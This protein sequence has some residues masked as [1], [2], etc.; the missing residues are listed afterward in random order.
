MSVT[1]KAAF[2]GK[3]ISY[4][5]SIVLNTNNIV[6]PSLVS[7]PLVF[8]L[9]MFEDRETASTFY[10]V[11]FQSESCSYSETHFSAGVIPTTIYFLL[12][13]FT[14]SFAATM[15]CEAMQRIPGNL[16]FSKRYEVQIRREC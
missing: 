16:N 3:T 15:L 2:G 10:G 5:G 8:Q 1:E 13:W 7:I 14:S 6:G 12:T 4:F 11:L 9:G